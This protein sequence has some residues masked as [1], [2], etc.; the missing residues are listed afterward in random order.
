[1][2]GNVLK[3]VFGS[4][5]ERELSRLRKVVVKINACEAAIQALSDDA[6]MAKTAEF[7]QQLVEGKTLDQLLP[8]AFACVR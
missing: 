7:R 4:K 5:N 8:E 6:L 2:I 1:M 3:K